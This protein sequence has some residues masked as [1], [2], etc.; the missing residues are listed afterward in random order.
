VQFKTV[1]AVEHGRASALC[2]VT[3]KHLIFAQLL[4]GGQAA[5]G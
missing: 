1:E 3:T 2:D 4:N 5:R